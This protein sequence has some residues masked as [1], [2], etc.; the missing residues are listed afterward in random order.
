MFRVRRNLCSYNKSPFRLPHAEPVYE[1][2]IRATCCK[3]WH[4]LFLRKVL[5]I[6]SCGGLRVC[7]NA[8]QRPSPD[9]SKAINV[10]LKKNSANGGTVSSNLAHAAIHKT[11][12]HAVPDHVLVYHRTGISEHI[13]KTCSVID[14]SVYFCPTCFG[15]CVCVCVC[16][17]VYGGTMISNVSWM[18][19]VRQSPWTFLYLVAY[20]YVCLCV[21]FVTTISFIFST[22][23]S[24]CFP[25]FGFICADI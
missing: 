10:R 12:Q 1:H 8:L 24:L 25:V 13:K 18:F 17:C 19:G 4:W 15:V 14:C 23:L 22:P 5:R 6:V 20:D 16:V 11:K 21:C 3:S 7:Q 9:N 2:K